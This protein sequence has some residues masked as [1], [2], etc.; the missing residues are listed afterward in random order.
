MSEVIYG[1]GLLVCVFIV[2]KVIFKLVGFFLKL[3]IIGVML[4]IALFATGI[5]QI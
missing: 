3:T 5:I 1:I 4:G 2:F